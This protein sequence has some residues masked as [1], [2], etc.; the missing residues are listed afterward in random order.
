MLLPVIVHPRR[1]LSHPH[2]QRQDLIDVLHELASEAGAHI[3]LNAEVKSVQPGTSA[4]P[5]P[6]VTLATGEVV[7]ADILIGA[8]G[9]NGITRRTIFVEDPPEPA[10]LT[11]YTGTIPGEVMSQDPELKP[12]LYAEEVRNS[13]GT[14]D[15][16]F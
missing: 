5:R 11:V 10:G 13:S 4:Q 3:T 9:H 6:T 8:D 1:A 14:D 7:T 15:H 12:H 16:A 2:I